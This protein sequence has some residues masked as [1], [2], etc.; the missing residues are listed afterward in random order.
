MKWIPVL[1][2]AA[3]LLWLLRRR[4][5]ENAG[6]HLAGFA[7]PVLLVNSRLE[8]LDHEVVLRGRGLQDDDR[9]REEEERAEGG[10]AVVEAQ[11]PGEREHA[12]RRREGGRELDE[13]GKDLEP[14]DLED[15]RDWDLP[16]GGRS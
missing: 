5:F 9:Q 10:C 1:T 12:D 7:I 8:T 6:V 15:E 11:A 14:R 16:F 3:L 2:L 4:R 13:C